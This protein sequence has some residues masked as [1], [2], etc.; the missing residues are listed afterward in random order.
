MESPQNNPPQ[1]TENSRNVPGRA[2]PVCGSG[3]IEIRAKLQCEKCH[4]ICE[5]CCEGGPG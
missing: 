4:T 5:T 3:L 2:C 1:S